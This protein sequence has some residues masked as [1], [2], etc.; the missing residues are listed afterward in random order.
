[1]HN[2][3]AKTCD[4]DQPGI[5]V[6]DH[7]VNVGCVAEALLERVGV[8]LRALL[9]AGSVT[10][11]ALHDVGKISTG[12]Q[13]K[14]P[15]WLVQAGLAE[16]ALRERWRDASES[17]HAK[18]SQYYLERAMKPSGTHL[19]A[20]A[21]GVHHGRI[22]GRRIA[23]IDV[24]AEREAWEIAARAELLAEL[25]SIFG[26]LP[27]QP[28]HENLS[29]LWCV[30]GLI[31]VADWIGSNESFFPCAQG[32]P[33]GESRE[34]A[35]RA[36]DQIHWQGGAVRSRTFGELFGGY[37]P[38]PLQCA[39]HE[40]CE[41]PGLFIVEGPMG[42]GKTEAA[43]WAAHR[44]IES[45]AND[46]MYFALPTQVTSNRIHQRVAPFLQS[47]LADAANLRLAHAAS[48]LE[49][50]QTWRL[51]PADAD[52]TA[53]VREG[54]SWFASSKHAM[55]ARFG[56]GTVDQA[57]QGVVAV[58]HFFVRRFGL[59]GKVVILDEVHS[60]DVYTGTLI[61]QL[62][63]E[64]LALRCSVIVLSATLT[65][66]RRQEL[67]AAADGE[68]A[69][70]AALAY[71][72][73]TAVKSGTP[74]IEIPVESPAPRG[75]KLNTAALSEEE[76]LL[77]CIERAEA[78]QHVLYLR[79]TVVEA[80]ETCR[81]AKGSVRD[82]H[83][84]VAT[85]HSRFPFFRR[86][87]LEDQWLE[88][89]GKQ[90]A[91]DGKG[92]L[93]IATQVVEQS[94]DIDLDFIV[95]DLAP[96]DM[97][98]QRMGR[99]WRHERTDRIASEPEFW[100]NAPVVDRDATA[101]ILSKAF[102]KSGLV[103]APYVLLRTAEVFAGRESLVLPT[104]IREV[105]EATYAEREE[106]DEPEAWCELRAEVEAEREKLA[107]E[108]DA[109][110]RVLGRQSEDDQ[111]EH[112]TRRKGAPTRDVVLVRACEM[113]ARDQ[114]QLAMLSG[115]SLMVSGYE[116]SMTAAQAIHRNLVRAPLHTVPGQI[117][118]S[119][120]KLHTHGP[121]FWALV[122]D[123][124]TLDFPGA[125]GPSALAYDSMLGLHTRP[126]QPQPRYTEDDDEFDY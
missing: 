57:L 101:K 83:G 7:C 84:E 21:A 33:L 112:L 5:S 97:L 92:S 94:V 62:I 65:Q 49:D 75:C 26:P 46:G 73:V 110:T 22:F 122:R 35:A 95:S 63:R 18:V 54:R 9:P 29:D 85:L 2:F 114:W 8:T 4:G 31:S 77:E 25:V 93:L 24:V 68:A 64:L 80:Q 96:T 38:M 121:T 41:T 37:A 47:A 109:A 56:V 51:H 90:R 28:P 48:W 123:D 15:V 76:I 98:L 108:A 11:A 70:A 124:G 118:P 105:L 44:L 119:W 32:L 78:G 20:V 106:G 60:Y 111:R 125:E 30:A 107:Q 115:E 42:C 61:S 74:L 17:D 116:W 69:S 67:I 55:L 99:L 52:D 102:G 82:T 89:L 104:Q 81:K 53:Q 91:N 12:F 3:W 14:C 36:L 39:L 19:W 58:K 59:A 103:Y 13:A 100:I 45:G 23:C 43:L 117:M 16:A 10:L 34:A 86:Q 50:H 72:L 79:N 87:E 88:R 27:H 66:A 120:L 1:M 113:I 40:Q 71:P 126:G 6:H